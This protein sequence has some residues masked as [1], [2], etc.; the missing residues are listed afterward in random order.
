M[1]HKLRADG[2]AVHAGLFDIHRFCLLKGFRN[3]LG[4]FNHEGNICVVSVLDEVDEE[5]DAVNEF[6][7]SQ[8]CAVVEALGEETLEVCLDD[9][10]SLILIVLH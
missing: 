2:V 8:L 7:I 6:L 4:N 9:Y 5:D 10:S 1:I 3:L